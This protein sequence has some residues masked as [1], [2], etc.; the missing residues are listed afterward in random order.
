MSQ[1][2]PWSV[3]G[4][5]ARAR[6]AARERARQEGM[7]LGE[8][9]NSLILKGGEVGAQDIVAPI[10]APK[11]KPQAGASSLNKLVSRIEAAE[12]RS[13]LAIT[14]IDQSV[15]GLLKRIEDAETEHIAMARHVD[16]VI[17][18]IRSTY[19]A[20]RD[21]VRKIEEDDSAEQNLEALK[22]LE[23]A[24]GKLA[25]HVYEENALAQSETDAI[26]GRVEMGFTDVNERLESMDTKV[27]KTL[28]D[29]A[30]R[31]E[32]AVEQAELR[33]EGTA[34]HL[35]E[36]MSTLDTKIGRQERNDE[37][38]TT[39]LDAVESKIERND[40]QVATRFEDTE[41]TIERN[42][43]KVNAR[44]DKT[45]A[46]LEEL[47]EQVD[48]RLS[49]AEARIQHADELVTA[50][51]DN[52]DEKLLQIGENIDERL[53]G[54]EAK[55]QYSDEKSKARLENAETKLE[56]FEE[57]FGER[58]KGAEARIERQERTDED[59]NGRVE[60]VETR[61]GIAESTLEDTGTRVDAIEG[62]VS[63]ALE[64]MEGTLLRIQ[65][66]LNRAETTTDAA[67]KSLESTFDVLD[68]RIG[69]VAK[70]APEHAFE[71]RKQFEE[72]FDGLADE[73]RASIAATRAE[74]AAE[75]ESVATAGIAPEQLETFETKLSDLQR[76][77]TES[78]ERQSGAI[79]TVG[80]QVNRISENFDKR[81]TDIEETEGSEHIAAEFGKLA[82]AVEE[83][84]E[85]LEDREST[86]IERV[87]D[88]MTKIADQ[89]DQ[90][91]SDSE[92]RSATAIEQVGE[93]VSR[94]ANKL[95][96]RQDDAFA[97]FARKIDDST[98]RS[99]ARLSDA[100]ANVSER[101]ELMQS[102]SASTLSPVQ[103][104]IASLATRLDSLEEFAAPPFAEAPRAAALPELHPL[105]INDPLFAN[106]KKAELD[107]SDLLEEIAFEETED[108][109]ETEAELE[110]EPEQ[111]PEQSAAPEI[112]IET[113]A[114]EIYG[115]LASTITV[116]VPDDERV[117]DVE[118]ASDAAFEPGI[119]SWDE[120]REGADAPTEAEEYTAEVPAPAAAEAADDPVSEL[121]NWDDSASEARDS[122]V[123]DDVFEAP[124]D[125]GAD[126]PK[127]INEEDVTKASVDDYLKN[128]RAAARNA[129]ETP[130]AAKDKRKSQKEKAPKA[131]QD[132]ETTGN[133]GSGSSKLPLIATASVVA[134]A[135]AGGTAYYAMKDNDTIDL[136]KIAT[137]QTAANTSVSEAN[138][139][140]PVATAEAIIEED[141]FE[142]PAATQVAS[143]APTEVTDPEQELVTADALAAPKPAVTPEPAK[144]APAAPKPAAPEETVL[145]AAA[146]Q[147]KAASALSPGSN[148]SVPRITLPVSLE[149]AAAS[150]DP[151]AMY[152]LAKSK[153]ETGGYAE[154]AAL[155]KRSADAGEPAAQYRLGKLHEKGLGVP[156]D[157]TQA[158]KWTETAANGGNIR[159]MH[160][161]AVF[162]AEGA[163]GPQ[164]YAA[165]V[166]W[167]RKAAEFGVV[168]SQ[169][170][171]GV[172]YERGIGIDPDPTEAMFWYVVAARGGDASSADKVQ[173][174]NRVLPID[175]SQAATTRAQNWTAK[176]ASGQANGI[177]PASDWGA[178]TPQH[179]KQV[180]IAL[181]AL[182]YEIGRPDG[183][184]G[185]STSKAIRNFERKYGMPSTGRVT[186]ELI[187]KINELA[188][189]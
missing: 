28:T 170:N 182:G 111:E 130:A 50:R 66:R 132:A 40:D 101:L 178:L 13:T 6:E 7:T 78:D 16:G 109:P 63:T 56:Q 77:L 52:A 95:Q 174:L 59:L 113:D 82:S 24:L 11:P 141:L 110:L 73:L 2:G 62:D 138:S 160:D 38:I 67:L 60:E 76:S 126:A 65:D 155:M 158:R 29:A 68:Q 12:A 5:D 84:L 96:S 79:E 137:P 89:L 30:R 135:T 98:N 168:D 115:D 32:R 100:L 35:S 171:L 42:D 119:E 15:V 162:Y 41:A 180:Q 74:L 120:V 139:P 34:R 61:I 176:Q 26:K 25:S 153:L 172:L 129:A 10:A 148:Q 47:G 112:E 51:L 54:A 55:I 156:R 114:A 44:I 14:G 36:R 46:K 161:L 102:Q 144:P 131:G 142:E 173:E 154:G 17:D 85:Q 49:D 165:A 1:T 80:E 43:E 189:S 64:S 104:A 149:S 136:Q 94:V 186:S 81:L 69:E 31:V 143:V 20:L 33:A 103:K 169:Y 87:G 163:G 181:N 145:T 23:N 18:D 22:A 157:L 27:E 48:E 140:A 39:R 167:F 116:D 88:E 184:V 128:A 3:K 8:Y 159:A 91:I 70:A 58:I 152:M 166:N 177:F 90:R 123:F 118:I 83:R 72:R 4:I 185:P 146:P 133:G 86:V 108:E 122:D 127:E 19:D 97:A 105:P 75:I 124:V 106:E 99:D 183:T 57:Q 21:K 121:E 187:A 151:K 150:G 117:E 179:I 147:P 45:D 92:Q 93:Q 175:I 134:L 37:Q 9:L 164:S 71:L 107:A 188:T 125:A 53:K